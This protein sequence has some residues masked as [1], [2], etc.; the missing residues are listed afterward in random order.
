MQLLVEKIHRGGGLESSMSGKH[1]Q[2]DTT[3]NR[4]KKAKFEEDGERSQTGGPSSKG[5]LM[6]AAKK[7]KKENWVKPKIIFLI[8]P[9]TENHQLVVRTGE[10]KGEYANLAVTALW[11]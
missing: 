10:S 1:W 4:G 5:A 7:P 3:P 6:K 11:V 2:K 8:S 9:E